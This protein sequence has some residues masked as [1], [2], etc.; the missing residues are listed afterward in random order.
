M[1]HSVF[2]LAFSTFL[3]DVGKQSAARLSRRIIKSS[4][5]SEIIME[6][7][8]GVNGKKTLS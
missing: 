8:A 1:I 7:Y 2:A 3:N 5:D 6:A 4:P